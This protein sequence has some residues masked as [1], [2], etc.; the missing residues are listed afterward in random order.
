VP[1]PGGQDQFFAMISAVRT[2]LRW[3]S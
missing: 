3:C 1:L 2:T